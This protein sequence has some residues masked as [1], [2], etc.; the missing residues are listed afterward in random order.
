MKDL[1]EDSF[2]PKSPAKSHLKFQQARVVWLELSERLGGCG[3]L[4][5][6]RRTS[7]KGRTR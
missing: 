3:D 6:L 4:S 1:R 7:L 2:D 5:G